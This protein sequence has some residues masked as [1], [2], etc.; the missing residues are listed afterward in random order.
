MQPSL[1]PD[2]QERMDDLPTENLAAYDHF[3]LGKYHY[4]RQLPGSMRLA[5]QNFEAA[6]SLDPEFAEAWDWLAYAYNHAA[7]A[8]GYLPPAE[9]YPKAR[10]AA[11]HALEIEPDLATSVSILGY[12]RAVYD[13]DWT[14]AEADLRRALALDSRDSGTVWSL[15]H[16]LSMMGRYEEAI[17]LTQD[18]ADQDPTPG[19]S[20]LEVANRLLD[21]GEYQLA[22][23]RLEQA[24]DNGAELAQVYDSKGIA[25][26]GLGDFENAADFLTLAVEARQR[27]AG[28]VARLAYVLAQLGQNDQ[29]QYLLNE[30]LDRSQSERIPP[31]TLATAYLA[32]GQDEAA[33]GLVEQA[34]ADHDR[35]VLMIGSDPFLI[36]LR[37]RDEFKSIIDGFSFPGA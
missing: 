34:A 6:V 19:R 28:A 33:M 24:A 23:E 30:L 21:A 2:I 35:E 8:V 32:L 14:G 25:Y 1:A 10:T 31:L 29:A 7:T 9:A 5:V 22:L 27:D 4:R 37:N 26:V 12:I 20:Y 3:I 13:W 17:A 18:F 16:V 11:L 15:A 36:R